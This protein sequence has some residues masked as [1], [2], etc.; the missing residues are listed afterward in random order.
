MYWVC[1]CACIIPC[2]S[3]GDWQ[4]YTLPVVDILF[5]P[6]AG[7]FV[8]TGFG[9]SA[10]QPNNDLVISH[11]LVSGRRFR[12]FC[13]SNSLTFDVGELIGLDGSLVVANS[14]FNFETPGNGGEL[15]IENTAG[16]EVP[17]TAS[18]QGVYTCRIP[19]EGGEEIREINIGVYP[20]GFN[21]ELF[22]ECLLAI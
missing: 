14:F 6:G 16:F 12:F 1:A 9:E 3:P 21:C 13:R 19:L 4:C 7:I 11:D 15:R 18:E 17:L 10:A 20:S 5:F 8:V 2:V 22:N